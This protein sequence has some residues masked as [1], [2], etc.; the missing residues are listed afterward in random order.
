MLFFLAG[1][2]WRSLAEVSSSNPDGSSKRTKC[3]TP[4][5]QQ[6]HSLGGA[7]AFFTDLYDVSPTSETSS[8]NMSMRS[9]TSNNVVDVQSLDWDFLSKYV[10]CF[11]TPTIFLNTVVMLNTY[12][13][14]FLFTQKIIDKLK[15]FKFLIYQS[16][17]KQYYTIL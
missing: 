12:D 6:S 4:G 16:M 2:N 7:S 17:N 3:N 1:R 8:L 9:T 11:Y 15:S 14:F 5:S 13:K 10:K